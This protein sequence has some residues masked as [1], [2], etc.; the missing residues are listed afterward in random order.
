MI[1][2]MK[3]DPNSYLNNMH[4]PAVKVNGIDVN[5]GYGGTIKQLTNILEFAGVAAF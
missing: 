1:G 5:S 2:L 3:Q 4:D